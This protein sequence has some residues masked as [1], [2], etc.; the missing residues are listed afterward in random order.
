MLCTNYPI[1]K[2]SFQ[3]GQEYVQNCILEKLIIRNMMEW[4]TQKLQ[5]SGT[6][7]LVRGQIYQ[8]AEKK[9][10]TKQNT[11]LAR[12]SSNVL[13]ETPKC[14]LAVLCFHKICQKYELLASA[15]YECFYFYITTPLLYFSQREKLGDTPFAFA[16]LP[17]FSLK[18]PRII[19]AQISFSRSSPKIIL[20][21]SRRGWQVL[22]PTQQ[23]QR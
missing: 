7:H 15:D 14:V 19:S 18:S 22:K 21:G 5:T 20:Q 23:L 17:S 8:K 4:M 12:T 6:K 13:V 10:K 11:W 16:V 9:K 3:M 2:K 1:G